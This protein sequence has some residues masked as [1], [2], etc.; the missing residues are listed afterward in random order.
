M[1]RSVTGYPQPAGDRSENSRQTALLAS[2]AVMGLIVYGTS[3]GSTGDPPSLAWSVRFAMLAALVAALGVWARAGRSPVTVA[4][5]AGAGFL[6]AL[7]HVLAGQNAGWAPTVI[8]VAAAAQTAVAV[9]ALLS[10]D[11]P[12]D[13]GGVA[14]YEAYV[15][16]YNEAVRTYYQ[17][18]QAAA[19]PQQRAGYG[20]AYGTAA[21]PAQHAHRPSQAAEYSEL[22]YGTRQAAAPEQN[23]AGPVAGVASFG[24]ASASAEPNRHGRGEAAPPSASV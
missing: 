7:W 5:L 4:A 9:A 18:Q 14:G 13:R 17:Q 3:L 2:A 24:H 20:Q 11:K 19:E 6:D 12:N 1:T 22:D 23:P 16:Y 10:G 8:T 15:D 21:A